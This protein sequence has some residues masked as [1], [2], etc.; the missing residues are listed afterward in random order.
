MNDV[1]KWAI[2]E[3]ETGVDKKNTFERQQY[4]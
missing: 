2:G 3:A 4:N 1:L